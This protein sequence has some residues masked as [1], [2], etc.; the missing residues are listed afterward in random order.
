MKTKMKTE[1]ELVNS[2][3]AELREEWGI[4]ISSIPTD[5]LV[6]EIRRCEREH[7]DWVTVKIPS[8]SEFGMSLAA[9]RAVRNVFVR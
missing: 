2:V 7:D 6:E 9:A 1:S 3:A 5:R 8:R 4:G